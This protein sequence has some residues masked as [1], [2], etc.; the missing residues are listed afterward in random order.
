MQ[1]VAALR[2]CSAID[3]LLPRVLTQGLESRTC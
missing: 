3:D 1:A 2:S